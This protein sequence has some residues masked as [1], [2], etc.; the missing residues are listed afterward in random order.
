MN[1]PAPKHPLF[2]RLRDEKLIH[3]LQQNLDII[4]KK[5]TANTKILRVGVVCVT[6]NSN[7]VTNTKPF[8]RNN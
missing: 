4:R 2:F 8:V 3:T 6:V 1:P 5:Q 7:S